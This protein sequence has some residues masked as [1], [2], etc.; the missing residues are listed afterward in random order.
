MKS[1]WFALALAI[2]GMVLA[3]EVASAGG[4]ESSP[5][6]RGSIPPPVREPE[7]VAAELLVKFRPDASAEQRE[8]ALSALQATVIQRFDFIG[9]EHVRFGAPV[10]TARAIATLAASPAV[11]Y[12]GAQ[13]PSCTPTCRRTTRASPACTSSRTPGR[14]AARRAPD[15]DAV[16]AWD[17]VHR[18]S[19]A[20]GRDPRHRHQLHAPRISPTTCGPTRSRPPARPASMTTTTA[21]STT[22]T[23]SATP[24]AARRRTTRRGPR[25]PRLGHH[26]GAQQQRHRRGGCE[27]ACAAGRDQDSRRR[28]ARQ[29]RQRDRRTPV[30]DQRRR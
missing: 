15:I 20:E 7:S 21:G 2:V 23:A 8:Q 9:V 5:A 14:P 10:S 25:Q 24:A 4:I 3:A 16:H 11:E 26:R 13:L 22:C 19:R 6:R 27:L 17:S 29:R 28:R 30:R 18:R 1:V 12:A